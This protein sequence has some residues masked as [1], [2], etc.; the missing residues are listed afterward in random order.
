MDKSNQS[1]SQT[2]DEVRDALNEH[3]RQI[4]EHLGALRSE[5][6]GIVSPVKEFIARHPVSSTCAALGVGVVLGHLIGGGRRGAGGSA[7]DRTLLDEELIPL[8]DG[9][10]ERLNRGE[11]SEEAV[12]GAIQAHV[13]VPQRASGG[14]HELFRLLLPVAVEMGL[15]AFDTDEQ[16]KEE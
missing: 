4:E 6:T 8:I 15:K 3:A 5:L 7:L 2:S 13:V 10:K 16:P 11:S 14:L 1:Q 9:V 12:R